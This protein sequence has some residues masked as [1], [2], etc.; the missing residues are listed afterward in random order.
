MR[1][2]SWKLARGLNPAEHG[3]NDDEIHNALQQ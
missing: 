3:V 2:L 1:E